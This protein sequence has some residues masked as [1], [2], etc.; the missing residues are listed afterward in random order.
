MFEVSKR[1]RGVARN[2]LNNVLTIKRG[3]IAVFYAGVENLDIA[4]AF[5]AECEAR[6][7]ETLVQSEGDYIQ[8]TRLL[9]TPIEVLEE[10]PRVPKALIEL[11][12]W[13]IF[14]GGTRH[15]RSVYKVE[16]NRE[17]VL[18]V[19]KRQKWT[20]DDLGNLCMEKGAHW[21]SCADPTKG[22]SEAL[23]KS[24]QEAKEMFLASLD[25]DYNELSKLGERIIK[26]M[27]KGGE[28]HMTCP[29]GS[30]LRLRADDRVWLNDDGRPFHE[31]GSSGFIHNLPVGEVFVP[32]IE[33]SAE[34]IIYPMDI[35]GNA[36]SGIE[37]EFR[38][39]KDAKVSAKTGFEFIE[40]TFKNATGNPLKIAEFAF[41]TNP[42]GNPFLATEKA[43]GTCH[44]AIGG[45]DFIGGLNKCSMHWDHVIESP[46]VTLDGKLILKDGEFRV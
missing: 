26:R 34:G 23:G 42:C 41:G 3:E 21:V 18:E 19:Q 28:I 43:Y 45:N 1:R 36:M 14:M 24:H 46:T 30:D 37:I 29:K 27:K 13:F 17:R 33:T 11:A 4:Y 31:K 32:P 25:I 8:N 15:D 20:V 2:V 44:V 40:G 16:E 39:D 9:E 10:T 6:G 35:P 5:A 12:D 7:I 22:M 38:G